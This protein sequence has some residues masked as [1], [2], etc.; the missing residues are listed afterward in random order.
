MMFLLVSIRNKSP[1]QKFLNLKTNLIMIT[2]KVLSIEPKSSYYL[3]ER[4]LFYSRFFLTL[5]T[6]ISTYIKNHGI[7]INMIKNENSKFGN[8]LVT[9]PHLKIACLSNI[10]KTW[11]VLKNWNMVVTTFRLW[12]RFWPFW[13]LYRTVFTNIES[14]TLGKHNGWNWNGHL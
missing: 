3:K 4:E 9:G 2:I 12:W 1:R 11:K 10:E 7:T 13:A 14:P 6:L 8:F 5:N